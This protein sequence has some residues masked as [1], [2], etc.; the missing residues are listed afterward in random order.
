MPHTLTAGRNAYL[1]T[2][3]LTMLAKFLWETGSVVITILA[4]VHLYYTFFTNK[5]SSR[6]EKMVEE[7]K[8]SFPIL[9]KKTTMW[10]AWIGFNGSHSSGAMFIGIIN[11]Y[12]AVYYFPFLQS[13]HFFFVFTIITMC[14]YGWLVKKYWFN[15]PFTGI[16]ISLTCFIASYILVLTDG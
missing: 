4:T 14:F 11:F 6:N 5:F 13:D 7:M 16:I 8:T 15:I 2:N 1:G 3:E 9:T 12:L 10:K